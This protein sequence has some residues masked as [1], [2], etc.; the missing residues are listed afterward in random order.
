M[1]QPTVTGIFPSTGPAAGG[2]PVVVTGT[3]FQDLLHPVTAVAFGGMN[4]ACFAPDSS[5]QITAASPPGTA[6]DTV[7]VTVTTSEGTSA[8]SAGD[9]FTFGAA[10]DANIAVMM[11]LAALAAMAATERPSGE[12]VEQQQQRILAG[13]NEQLTNNDLATDGHW[14]AIWVGLTRDRA[15][16]AYIAQNAS[17]EQGQSQQYAVCL[18]GTQGFVIDILEDVEVGTML[19]FMGGKISQGAMEAFT[20]VVMGTTLLQALREL[21]SVQTTGPTIYVTGHSLGGALAT[22]VSLYLAVQSWNPAP[23]FQVYTFAAPTAGDADFATAFNTQFPTATC[24]WSQYDIVPN[25]WWNLVDAANVGSQSPPIQE[26]AEYF[27]PGMPATT[28]KEKEW[29]IW[30]QGLISGIGDLVGS[31]VYVQ[32]QPPQQPPLVLNACFDYAEPQATQITTFGDWLLEL[33]NQHANNTY[34]TLLGA[35]PVPLETPSVTSVSPTSGPSAGWTPVTVSGT[36]SRPTAW[37]TSVSSQQ[38][39]SA[40]RRTASRPCHPLERGS[41]T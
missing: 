26:F 24:V 17:I 38:R 41:S 7:D 2:T 10:V 39:S 32:P 6:G 28:A 12:T 3:G 13:I 16:M 8:T 30:K 25:A 4:A 31:N 14:Q 19:P 21:V 22:T 40:A 27:Y 15:N 36:A 18:R 9:Q 29:H 11:T 20:E 33:G 5:T 1:S 35:Q 34:L 37:S 23:T